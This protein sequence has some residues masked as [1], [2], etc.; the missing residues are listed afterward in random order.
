M[1]AAIF[2]VYILSPRL[3]FTYGNVSH[4]KV[5]LLYYNLSASS[6]VLSWSACK[7]IHSKIIL[8]LSSKVMQS[9]GRHSVHK[10]FTATFVKRRMKHLHRTLVR[11]QC[12]F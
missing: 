2:H 3:C 7:C 10:G 6:V 8:Y 1:C 4:H 9:R 11:Q 12:V 5:Y